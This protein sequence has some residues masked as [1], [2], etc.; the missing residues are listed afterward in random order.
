[1][2]IFSNCLSVCIQGGGAVVSAFGL[3]VLQ[4]SE[5][6]VCV[7]PSSDIVLSCYSLCFRETNDDDDVM[8]DNWLTLQYQT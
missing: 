2:L 1:M 8:V 3:S 4:S 7:A 5:H 6:S